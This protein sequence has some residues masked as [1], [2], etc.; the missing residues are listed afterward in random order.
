MDW[1]SMTGEER[2]RVVEM[3]RKGEKSKK[4]ICETFGISRQ[5]L[6][7]AVEKVEQVAMEALKPK[8]PGR[9]GKSEEEKKIMELSKTQSSLEKDVK[10][11]KT[12]YEV[13]QAF[14]DIT[15]EQEEAELR[16]ERNRSKRERRKQKKKPRSSPKP[17]ARAARSAGTGAGMAEKDDGDSAGNQRVESGEMDET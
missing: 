8:P 4:E 16:T 1:K 2:Y 9:K 14:I 10:H 15:R 6:N 12:R 7:R 3:A 13:A 5:T 11:W 17:A